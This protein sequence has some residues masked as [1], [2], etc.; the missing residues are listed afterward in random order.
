VIKTAGVNVAA[1]E[2]EAVLQQHPAVKVAH[3]VGVPH[4]TRGENVAAAIVV[5][6]APRQGAGVGV[7]GSS[8]G[9]DE[10]R[11]AELA[12]HCGERL[13]TYKVPRHFLFITEDE[14]PILGS[15][16]VDKKALRVMIEKAVTKP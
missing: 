3:V 10:E 13:A 8:R 16:K 12:A 5:H 6:A 9:D 1:A 15:G 2:V 14:L 4:P 11:A 7:R